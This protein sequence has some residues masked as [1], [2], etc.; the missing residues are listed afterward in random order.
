[1]TYSTGQKKPNGEHAAECIPVAY[2]Q[3]MTHSVSIY[4]QAVSER[5]SVYARQ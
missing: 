2:Q 4:S 5:A 1:M 3:I